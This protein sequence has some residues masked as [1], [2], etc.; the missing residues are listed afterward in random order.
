MLIDHINKGENGPNNWLGQNTQPNS[1]EQTKVQI[2]NIINNVGGVVDQ[3]LITSFY[4]NFNKIKQQEAKV[5]NAGANPLLLKANH[6]N[7]SNMG[8]N[9]LKLKLQRHQ[10][11]HSVN[12]TLPFEEN[13]SGSVR[14]IQQ[15]SPA[16]S[17]RT[18][19]STARLSVQR[20]VLAGGVQPY[21]SRSRQGTS[22]VTATLSQNRA[23]RSPTMSQTLK[24]AI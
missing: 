16:I 7:L 3:H 22:P 17:P 20:S 1:P 6:Q 11:L 5:T 4:N 8:I 19:N 12:K 21:S 23:T 24:S 2:G 9:K 14:Y 13:P 15:A 10:K 18:N